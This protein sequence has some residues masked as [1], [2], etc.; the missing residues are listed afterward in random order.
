M[1]TEN[2]STGAISPATILVVDDD[3][4]VVFLIRTYLER[5]PGI[6]VLQAN[7]GHDALRLAEEEHPD[8]ILLDVMMPDLD[9]LAVCGMLQGNSETSGIPVIMLT[10]RSDVN[11]A[12]ESFRRGAVNYIIKPIDPSRLMAKIQETISRLGSRDAT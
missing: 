5:V 3:T 8:V 12:V 11:T 10:A 9:G 1:I 6:R 4:D 7:N 2:D